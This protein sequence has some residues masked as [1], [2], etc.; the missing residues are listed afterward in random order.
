VVRRWIAFVLPAAVLAAGVF[1]AAEL[2][3]HR[4][5][6]VDAQDRKDDIREELAAKNQAKLLDAVKSLEALTIKEQNFWARTSIESARQLATRNRKEAALL[7]SAAKAGRLAE[8][9]KVFA[10]LEKTCTACHDLHFEKDPALK[11]R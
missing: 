7:L 3:A 8:A 10:Q 1:T 4:Q 5:W 11:P 2:D 6:M 9:E